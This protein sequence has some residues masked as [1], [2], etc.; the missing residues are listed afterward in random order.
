[1]VFFTLIGIF[2]IL[3]NDIPSFFQSPQRFGIF[4]IVV[5]LIGPFIYN[6]ALF[7]FRLFLGNMLNKAILLMV[8]L[9]FIGIVAGLPSMVGRGGF[10]G[11]FNHSMMLGPM[12]SVAVLVA[13]F[14]AHLAVIKKKYWFFIV[15]ASLSFITCVAAGS[16]SALLACLAGSIFFYYKLNQGKITR[17][18]RIILMVVILGIFSF[19]LW[20]P[21]TERMMEKIAYSEDQGDALV[22]R[23][24]LWEMRMIE[25]QSSPWIGVGFAAVDIDTSTKFSEEDG[26]VEPGSS[27]LAILSMT[28]L[29]GFLPILILI[30][31]N[32]IVLIKDREYPIFSALLG[33]LLVLF[34]VHMMA[35]GYVLSAG[36]GLFFYFWLILGNIECFKRNNIFLQG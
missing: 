7:R 14:E 11:L 20:E 33:G 3:L 15:L 10:A 9:S 34:I 21:F 32:I 1:M 36:S 18:V 4:I 23:S 24:G 27:W 12:A 22:T 8:I 2:S 26:K 25:F 5:G 29:L 6:S 13:L 17:F 35:E 31:N 16:R 19:P 28:G 30:I